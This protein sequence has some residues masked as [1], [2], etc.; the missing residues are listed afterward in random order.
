MRRWLL[1][2][3]LAACADRNEPPSSTRPPAAASAASP[4]NY[5]DAGTIAVGDTILGLRIDSLD[6]QRVFEDSV[7]SGDVRFQG[8]IEVSGIYQAHFDYPEVNALCFHLDSLSALRIPEFAPDRW[9]SPNGKP[10]FCFSNEQ[11]ARDLLGPPDSTR[12]ARIVID[13]YH[14]T[15]HFTD[16]VD[17]ATL[18]RVL[19]RGAPRPRT[20]GDPARFA[21]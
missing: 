19:S 18:V 2:G 16:A 14:Q 1:L 17:A 10:W 9:S 3:L 8:E 20:L 11:H 5:F 15:R 7:W 6:V 21:K 4:G 12:W 13:Q